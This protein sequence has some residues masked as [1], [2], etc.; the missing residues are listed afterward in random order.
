VLR[1]RALSL[2]SNPLAVTLSLISVGCSIQAHQGEV[3][4]YLADEDASA[5]D[6]AA[7]TM[8]LRDFKVYDAN[9]PSTNPGFHNLES[10]RDVAASAL[11]SDSKPVY[12]SP[13]N[14]LPTFGQAS[15]D[16]WYRDVP[17]TNVTVVYPLPFSPTGD[18]SYEYD[19][20]K[21]GMVDTSA[22][23]SR[24]VFLPIDDGAPYATSFGNQG[25]PHN[26]AFTGELHAVFTFSGQG[27]LQV[28]GDDDLYVFINGDLSIN[29]G[30]IHAADTIDLDLSGLGLTSGHDY[31]LDLFYAERAGKIGELLLHTSFA[32]RP[33]ELE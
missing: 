2:P 6:P 15:F 33:P 11:G 19:S 31:P 1:K 28:R 29:R 13:T 10:D 8:T 9:D 5:A 21:N 20:R 3:G 26:L 25:T 30:G 4:I 23:V 22:G 27:S 16:Q 18:G 7:L 17:G 32:L 24:N 14:A 12:Q